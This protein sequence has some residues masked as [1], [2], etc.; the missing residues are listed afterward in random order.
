LL[1]CSQGAHT[2]GQAECQFFAY[3]LYDFTQ[4]SIS[5]PSIAPDFLQELRA[6]C[7]AHGDGSDKVALDRGSPTTF[8]TSYFTNVANGLGVL[9]S[10]QNLM[11]DPITAIY[12]ARYGGI[13]S[14]PARGVLGSL[15]F[16]FA[17]S[18][19]M[20]K[21]GNIGVKT[22]DEGEIR[23]VCTRFNRWDD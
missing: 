3:R 5:D 13:G 7:P 20:V 6:A 19:A 11:S 10:D 21:M 17:F 2:L 23:R 14:G 9:E 15:D 22:G 8:D 18:R 1:A 16:G 4:A 12:V